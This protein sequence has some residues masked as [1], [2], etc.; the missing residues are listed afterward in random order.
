MLM[1]P[2][3]SWN[4]AMEIHPDPTPSKGHLLHAQSE[5]LFLAA[6]PHQSDPTTGGHHAVP[7]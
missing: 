2:T 7:R 4:P 3:G 5:T 6:L 1:T